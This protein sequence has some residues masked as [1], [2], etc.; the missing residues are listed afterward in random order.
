[1]KHSG[2]VQALADHVRSSPDIFPE[3][4]SYKLIMAALEHTAE[5][6]RD[7][8]RAMASIDPVDA[9]DAKNKP[10]WAKAQLKDNLSKAHVLLQKRSTSPGM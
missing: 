1:M 2:H 3:K 9:G 10:G 7:Q 4:D 8:V 6:Q 5:W